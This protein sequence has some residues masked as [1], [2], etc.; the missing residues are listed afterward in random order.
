NIDQDPQYSGYS[1]LQKIDLAKKQLADTVAMADISDPKILAANLLAA[2]TGDAYL[3]QLFAG[4]MLSSSVAKTLVKAGVRDAGIN[5]GYAG[6]SQYIENEGMNKAGIKTESGQGVKDQ[7]ITGG[8]TGLAMGGVPAIIGHV[9]EGRAA[10]R[11]E[12]ISD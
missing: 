5:A 2:Y 3:G 1:D 4:R 6:T 8:L 7:M 9:R 10:G 11:G 12:K